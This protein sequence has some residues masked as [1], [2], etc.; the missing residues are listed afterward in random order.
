METGTRRP[1]IWSTPRLPS[2]DVLELPIPF[3]HP[4]LAELFQARVHATT[5]ARLREVL[6]LGD[7]QVGRLG[8]LLTAQPDQA[9]DRRIGGG[10]IGYFGHACLL[11][12]PQAAI[13][14]D[15]RVSA[16]ASAASTNGAGSPRVSFRVTERPHGRP[17][18]DCRWQGVNLRVAR[19]VAPTVMSNMN[20][21]HVGMRLLSSCATRS[22][23]TSAWPCPC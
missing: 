6:E 18:A 15:P 16:A 9:G 13:V 12:T 7:E 17:A 4:G 21:S 8:R 19:L 23:P 3:R 14:T 11:Q 20:T 1:F 22:R 5:L 10:R 2:P